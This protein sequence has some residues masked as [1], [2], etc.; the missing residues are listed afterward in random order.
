[1]ALR[2]KQ[3]KYMEARRQRVTS[4]QW[5]K[6]RGRLWPS[7]WFIYTPTYL[8]RLSDDPDEKVNIIGKETQVARSFH[9]H[10]K[11]IMEANDK[12]SSGFKRSE[13]QNKPVDEE[14]AK[15]LHALGYFD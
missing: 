15:Q 11:K 14:I 12:L 3:Y 6:A 4:R 5:L 8:F 2:N 10:M 7:P 13:K 1:M 9:A